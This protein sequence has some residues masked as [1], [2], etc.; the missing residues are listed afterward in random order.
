MLAQSDRNGCAL[1]AALALSL[2]WPSIRDVLISSARRF[3]VDAPDLALSSAEATNAVAIEAS[4]SVAV[5]RAMSFGAQQ[6]L[7][8]HRGLWDLLEARQLAR[9]AY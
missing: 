6:I 1:G 8:Q 7:S 2:D 9:G 4:S 5:E 3:G